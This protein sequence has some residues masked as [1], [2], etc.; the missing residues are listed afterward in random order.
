M[1][2]N[3]RMKK[4]LTLILGI[5][6]IGIVDGLSCYQETANITSA[7][8]EECGLNYTGNYSVGSSVWTTNPNYL[9]DGDWST[10]SRNNEMPPSSAH[11]YINYTKPTKAINS[12]GWKIKV[13]YS[14]PENYTYSLST[15]WNNSESQVR[16]RIND[17][18]WASGSHYGYAECYDGTTWQILGFY[19]GGLPHVWFQGYIY[20]EAINWGIQANY[21]YN[22]TNGTD[23]I[24]PSCTVNLGSI[25]SNYEY[26]QTSLENET[27]TCTLSGYETLIENF[28]PMIEGN[29]TWTM[30]GKKLTIYFNDYIGSMKQTSGYWTDGIRTTNFSSTNITINKTNMTEGTIKIYF[31]NQTGNY[32]YTQYYEFVNDWSEDVTEN[33]TLIINETKYQVYIRV[34]DES[35]SPING[36]LVRIDFSNFKTGGTYQNLGQRFTGEIGT[37]GMTYFWVDPYT[38]IDIRVVK[39]GY[40]AVTKVVNINNGQYTFTEPLPITMTRGENLVQSLTSFIICQYYNNLS[41]TIPIKIYAPSRTNIEFNTSYKANLTEISLNA[42]NW[43]SSTMVQGTHYC[44]NCEDDLLVYVYSNDV[45]IGTYKVN[46]KWIVDT[47][48][49]PTGTDSDTIT[50]FAWVFLILASGII[51]LILGRG[52]GDIGSGDIGKAVFLIGCLLI[53]MI[54]NGHFIFLLPIIAFYGVGILIKKWI[55]E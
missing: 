36:A 27:L 31:G 52:E 38:D 9:Y 15:C 45:L 43:G 37:N 23:W 14:P 50:K 54:F 12:T 5:M 46:Y 8:D 25:D 21:K 39:D 18:R 29:K 2:G 16:V 41:T 53:P 24:Y 22:F 40:T 3:S 32:N 6:L 11:I 26:I 47:I 7:T 1:H 4:I 51:G 20:E 10:G 48:D 42:F 13:H 44:T 19:N 49:T 28:N 33:L 30:T 55:Q 17:T 34:R 35:G